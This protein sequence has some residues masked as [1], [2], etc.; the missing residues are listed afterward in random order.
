[1][2]SSDQNAGT[3]PRKRRRKEHEEEETWC[4]QLDDNTWL[5]Y[6]LD[7][8]WYTGGRFKQIDKEGNVKYFPLRTG[9]MDWIFKRE[10]LPSGCYEDDFATTAD[11][12][13]PTYKT[14]KATKHGESSVDLEL[15]GSGLPPFN[16]TR[17]AWFGMRHTLND[18]ED[19]I[20]LV[21]GFLNC[22]CP[23]YTHVRIREEPYE[24]LERAPL[25]EADDE[26]I[27]PEDRTCVLDDNTYLLYT[28]D[29]YSRTSGRLKQVEGCGTVKFLP[30][31]SEQITWIFEPRTPPSGSFKDVYYSPHV[32]YRCYENIKATKRGESSVDLELLDSNFPPFN[33]TH[34]AWFAGHRELIRSYEQLTRDK[35]QVCGCPL[36]SG[37]R[38]FNRTH[39]CRELGSLGSS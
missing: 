26:S 39:T 1:M 36:Y 11:V 9:V 12:T 18:L 32:P 33:L 22:K 21:H 28:L 10:S 34:R 4:T 14:I 37:V 23:R 30:L 6:T 29:E 16:L 35:F 3:P 7:D 17:L 5:L 2:S 20:Q 31:K 15:L 27:F 38:V 19:E 13:Y 25:C 8:K 24:C